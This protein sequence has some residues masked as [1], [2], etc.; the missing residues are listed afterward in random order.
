MVSPIASRVNVTIVS[1]HY[2]PFLNA[3]GCTA[4][5]LSL[6]TAGNASRSITIRPS[7]TVS[8]YRSTTAS[9]T[10]SAKVSG[11]YYVRYNLTGPHKALFTAPPA[12]ALFIYEPGAPKPGPTLS[13]V[14]FSSTGSAFE[15][16][17]SASSDR[18]G[19]SGVFGC[20]SLVQ[21]A[22]VDSATCSWFSSSLL[23][24]NLDSSASLLPGNAFTL[25]GSRLKAEC[26]ATNRNCT[27]WAYSVEESVT[28]LNP[29]TPLLPSVQPAYST[30]IAACS[31]LTIDASSATGSGGRAMAYR[32]AVA[33]SSGNDLTNVTAYLNTTAN[34]GDGLRTI[35]LPGDFIRVRPYRMLDRHIDRRVCLDF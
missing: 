13:S 1:A 28:I 11:C 33:S 9:F 23:M 6:S 31:E 2:A 30:R 10:L 22:G 8:F 4:S 18:A 34:V 21:F 15:V 20:S 16:T 3:A 5:A 7:R 19:L 29:T 25:R 27:A 35:R 12:A 26:V 32:W 17:L 24:V 14:R